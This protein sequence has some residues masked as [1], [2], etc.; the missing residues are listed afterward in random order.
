[1]LRSNVLHMEMLQRL[2]STGFGRLVWGSQ[3]SPKQADLLEKTQFS[4]SKP[5]ELILL[6]VPGYCEKIIEDIPVIG[7]SPKRTWTPGFSQSNE[8]L[9]IC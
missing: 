5:G 3:V 9:E 7:S 8:S 1:M 4:R 2:Q 6:V